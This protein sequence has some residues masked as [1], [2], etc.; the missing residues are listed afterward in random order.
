[1]WGWR[2]GPAWLESFLPPESNGTVNA[3]CPQGTQGGGDVLI[4]TGLL[5]APL[6]ALSPVFQKMHGTEGAAVTL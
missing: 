2:E 4:E 1:M 5:G 3:G 6:S